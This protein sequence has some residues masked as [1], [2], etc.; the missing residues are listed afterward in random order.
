MG[1]IHSQAMQYV[2]Q[3]VLQRLFERFTQ[4]QRASLQLLIQRLLVAAGG[5]ERIDGFKVMLAYGGGQTS[6]IALAFLR[7]AQLSIAARSPGT[8]S[9]RV[10]A[11]AQAGTS[12]TVLGNIDRAFS[13]MMLYDD[14]RVDLLILDNGTL[15]DF[16]VRQAISRDQQQA[17]R[18]DTLVIGHLTAGQA[19]ATFFNRCYLDLVELYRQGSQWEGGV[20]AVINAVPQPKRKR[21]MA[22][23]RRMLREAGGLNQHP[24]EAF[25]AA[26][27]QGFAMLRNK[28][29]S[30]TL[31]EPMP[32][33]TAEPPA[34]A[35]RFLNID[36]LLIGVEPGT[37]D[38]FLSLLGLRFDDLAFGYN[39]SAGVNPLLVAHFQ[40]LRAEYVEGRSYQAGI[41]DYVRQSLQLARL[42]PMPPSLLNSTRS[43]QGDGAAERQRQLASDLAWQAYGL[44]ETQLV[45]L[46]FAPFV[47]QGRNLSV[48]LNRCAPGMLA[49]TPLLHKALQAKPASAPVIQWLENTSGLPLET[50]QMLYQRSLAN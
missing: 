45:C 49:A 30:Q 2:Y 40:G 41:D 34:R 4:A 33:Q 27:F 3:Q 12:S 5:A 11:T 16:D 18:R 22:W 47:D 32:T 38:L 50:L 24:L 43:Q 42:K 1:T 48:F 35:P 7:A 6:A 10:V 25:P 28:Q 44:S 37:G 9:L 17:E 23:G 39:E 14:P 29:H 31:G 19:R 20:D 36:D 26:M 13:A 8:F 21:Y 46:L 15:R